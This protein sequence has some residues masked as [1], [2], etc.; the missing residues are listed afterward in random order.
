[1]L[2]E[3]ETLWLNQGSPIWLGKPLQ[4]GS[5]A[6]LGDSMRIGNVIELE[7]LLN[8]LDRKHDEIGS[9]DNPDT[10]FCTVVNSISARL[11][12]PED[13]TAFD[14]AVIERYIGE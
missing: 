4:L 10:T 6:K 8:L 9:V 14:A 1:M 11:Q 7:T 2:T 3:Q 12:E 13:K 5:S